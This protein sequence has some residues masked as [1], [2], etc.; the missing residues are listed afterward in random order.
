MQDSIRSF[1]C[2]ARELPTEAGAAGC[3]ARH[4]A[5]TNVASRV[6]FASHD[7]A[8]DFLSARQGSTRVRPLAAWQGSRHAHPERSA[9]RGARCL[10]GDP[11]VEVLPGRLRAT[12]IVATNS[13]SA[14]E[15]Q[16]HA[17]QDAAPRVHEKPV[18]TVPRS[19]FLRVEYSDYHWQS[20]CVETNSDPI[21]G[22]EPK[23]NTGRL[24]RDLHYLAM[25]S[26]FGRSDRS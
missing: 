16:Y 22:C 10:D 26:R 25:D 5:H 20:R 4:V 7:D 24:R 17:R 18:A 15:G 1:C 6:E 14:R 9:P 13:P 2:S 11:S 19:P 21:A 12:T 8:R 3:V 23:A